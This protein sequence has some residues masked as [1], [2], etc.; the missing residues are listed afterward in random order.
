MVLQR[1][2]LTVCF[3]LLTCVLISF[4]GFSLNLWI[5][6]CIF[7]FVFFIS[8]FSAFWLHISGF[9]SCR[10]HF[11]SFFWHSPFGSVAIHFWAKYTRQSCPH[12]PEDFVICYRYICLNRCIYA[13]PIKRFNDIVV[14]YMAMRLEYRGFKSTLD[15]FLIIIFLKFL[16]SFWNCISKFRC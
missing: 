11:W 6:C 13:I 9:Y 5:C 12:F 2:N 15:T 10:L 14:V 4:F 1:F 3:C 8:C 7:D 16:P